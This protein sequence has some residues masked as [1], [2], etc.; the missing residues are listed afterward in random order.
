MSRELWNKN[1]AIERHQ[2]QATRQ[3]GAVKHK[4]RD[5]PFEIHPIY[6]GS[7]KFSD[8]NRNE[9]RESLLIKELEKKSSSIRHLDASL[10]Q[11]PS[12]SAS[13]ALNGSQKNVYKYEDYGGRRDSVDHRQTHYKIPTPSF[14]RRTG[15]PATK[16]P[17]RIS[18]GLTPLKEHFLNDNVVKPSL[19]RTLQTTQS[20]SDM[21]RLK[22]TRIKQVKS[23][24]TVKRQKIHESPLVEEYSDQYHSDGET[25]S[26]KEE[27][28]DKDSDLE[29]EEHDSSYDETETKFV[30][31][32]HKSSERSTASVNEIDVVSHVVSELL[33]RLRRKTEST[34]AKKVIHAFE[35]E[36][37]VKFLEMTDIFDNY[38]I[39]DG[40]VKK[41]TRNISHLRNELFTIR[42]ARNDVALKMHHLR[43]HHNDINNE[44]QALKSI[45]NFL[46][47][48]EILHNKIP[49]DVQH[50]EKTGIV[51]L[52][53]TV[54]PFMRKSWG[55]LEHLTAF[56][57]FLE[58]VDKALT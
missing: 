38:L 46:E 42:K 20:V 3:R 37:S 14:A 21:K 17:P 36:V 43:Q 48:I 58:K 23:G 49:S 9:N 19:K 56:N 15:S 7:S 5:V 55:I 45:Q 11:S 35:D 28:I 51:S 57:T 8:K 12:I 47:E 26:D 31:A 6:L 27:N 2:K 39:L 53:H 50:T 18:V 54:T 52:L 30:I 29:D 41:S 13:R 4:V 33:K 24:K 22:K 16:P 25:G 40:A 34:Y 44:N 1:Q 10:V 32:V